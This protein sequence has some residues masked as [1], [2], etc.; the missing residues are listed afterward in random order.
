[1]RKIGLLGRRWLVS[2]KRNINLFDLSS[3]WKKS[4]FEKLEELSIADDDNELEI[5]DVEEEVIRPEEIHLPRPGTAAEH[6][7]DIL[8]H[9]HELSS[10]EDQ[11]HPQFGR[12]SK[13]TN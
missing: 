7:G 1:M 10:D 13:R 5:Q 9:Q 8:L 3:Q 6:D 11:Y 2:R 4:V 12:L